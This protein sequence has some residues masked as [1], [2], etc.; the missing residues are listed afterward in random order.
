MNRSLMFNGDGDIPTS[1]SDFPVRNEA[2]NFYEYISYD[3][4]AMSRTLRKHYT[5]WIIGNGVN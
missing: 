4:G 5:T 2:V 1:G 3:L